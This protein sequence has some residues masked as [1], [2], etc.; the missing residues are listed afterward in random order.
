[1]HPAQGLLDLVHLAVIDGAAW[2]EIILI[3]LDEINYRRKLF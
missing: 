3:V 1:L 2:N